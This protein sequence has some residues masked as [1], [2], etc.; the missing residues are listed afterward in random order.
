MFAAYFI[1]RV[2]DTHI[3][4]L[5]LLFLV[6]VI[7][8]LIQEHLLPLKKPISQAPE[9]AMLKIRRPVYKPLFKLNRVLRADQKRRCKSNLP[10]VGVLAVAHRSLHQD[11]MLSGCRG[12]T[13]SDV[14]LQALLLSLPSPCDFFTLSPNREPVHRLYPVKVINTAPE[15]RTILLQKVLFHF[16]RFEKQMDTRK[17]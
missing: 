12:T 17:V 8:P 3:D 7:C 4:F 15:L 1:L 16:N 2:R 10:R 5:R 6:S 9:Y 11:L 13:A 14:C